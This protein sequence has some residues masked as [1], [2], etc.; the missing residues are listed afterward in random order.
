MSESREKKSSQ[1][2]TKK[3]A[4]RDAETNGD[5][6]ITVEASRIYPDPQRPKKF[7][8]PLNLT[9]LKDSIE[10]N[11]Q[12]EPILVRINEN[13]PG[14]YL[15]VDGERRW[16]ALK[17][18]NVKEIL[19]R[20]VA[21][22]SEAYEIITL[23]QNI[24]REELLPIE[25]ALT[26]TKLLN[27]MK[28]DNPK[29]RQRRLIKKVNLSE[30]YIS[31][32]LKMGAVDDYIVK[33]ALTSNFWSGAKLLALAKIQ[34]PE[35][36]KAK[37]EEFKEKIR[38]NIEKNVY[39]TNLGNQK[40]IRTTDYFIAGIQRRADMLVKYLERIKKKKIELGDMSA[41]KPSLD[42]IKKIIKDLDDSSR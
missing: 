6:I 22:D 2:R 41:L 33:E 5:Q 25:K 7:L 19:C 30:T 1:A 26:L 31:E 12:I 28:G 4:A 23:T 29:V 32:L 36:R 15:I 13:V 37:F 40:V 34:D 14:T 16:R 18:L 21:T 24:H 8:N 38:E 35:A 39:L 17:D 20:V 11:S 9:N 27:K 10:R 42:R 3:S